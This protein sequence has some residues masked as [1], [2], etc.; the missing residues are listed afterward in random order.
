MIFATILGI[1]ASMWAYLDSAY[2][3]GI[4]TDWAGAL[5]FGRLERWLIH[6][7]ETNVS[8][9]VAI[10]FGFLISAILM[11]MGGRFL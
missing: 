9:I 10:G 2:Q 4:N 11:V 1:I 6:P 3:G 5:A 7:S 8:A